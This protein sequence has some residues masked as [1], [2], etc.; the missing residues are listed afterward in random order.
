MVTLQDGHYIGNC[1]L[2]VRCRVARIDSIIIK[3]KDGEVVR[4]YLRHC[5]N[6]RDE[7]NR[8]TDIPWEDIENAFA[9]KKFIFSY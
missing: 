8:F 4:D 3:V 2:C 1:P 7:N 9:E 5:C 6:V